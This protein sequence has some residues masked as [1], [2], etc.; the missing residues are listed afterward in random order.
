MTHAEERT[1]AIARTT[2]KDAER[3]RKKL[4]AEERTAGIART[5]K[6]GGGPPHPEPRGA[7]PQARSRARMLLGLALL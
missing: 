1:A 3:Q 6:P 5:A 4:S 7:V 2:K